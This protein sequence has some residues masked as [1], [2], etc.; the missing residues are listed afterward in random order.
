MTL[1][2]RGLCVIGTHRKAKEVARASEYVEPIGIPFCIAPA[3][4][5]SIIFELFHWLLG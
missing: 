3:L 1:L 2:L 5:H 4:V